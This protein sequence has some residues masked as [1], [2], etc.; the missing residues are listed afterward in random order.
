MASPPRFVFFSEN[1]ISK[2]FTEV[3]LHTLQQVVV[4]SD[5]RH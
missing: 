1:V 5:T 4:Q 3:K 2:G